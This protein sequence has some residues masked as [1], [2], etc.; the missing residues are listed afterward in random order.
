RKNGNVG[1][2]TTVPLD[3]LHVNGRVRFQTVEYFEDGGTS[4]IEAR[5]DIRPS[6][7]NVYDLGTS[8]HRYDDVYATNGTINTSDRRDKKNI[9]SMPYGINEI[10]ALNPII[11]QWKESMDSGFKLGLIAQDLEEVLPEVVKKHDYKVSEEDESVFTRVE[12][13]RLGVYYSDII[14]VLVKGMQDQ[15]E[16]IEQMRVELDALKKELADSKRD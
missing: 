13:D 8:S 16:I 5:G 12:A 9:A 11:Y 3:A 6:A 7:D 2:G 4:E 14:P 10:L 1:I 15:N